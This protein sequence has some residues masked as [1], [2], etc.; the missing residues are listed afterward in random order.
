MNRATCILMLLILAGGC[1]VRNY[2]MNAAGDA[3][4]QSGSAIGA[5]HDPELVRGAAPFSLKLMESVLAETPRHAGLLEAAARG[6]TQ[7]AYTFVQQ[8][9]ERAEADDV[10]LAKAQRE[11]ARRLYHRARDYGLRALE[12]RHPGFRAQFDHDPRGAL[13]RLAREDSGAL[14]WTTI[15]WAAAIALSKESAEAVADL[16]RVDALVRRVRE[17]DPDMD[18]GGLH[19]FLIS[20]E[21]GRPGAANPEAQARQHLAHAL[22]LSGGQ[23]AGPYVA[24]A[25]GACVPAQN[26]REFVA[27]LEKALAIDPGARAEWRLENTIMQKRARWLLARADELFVE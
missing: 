16:R 12:A 2:A 18:A 21:M 5:H 26:R 14:Y 23:K 7:Y 10:A 6:F 4:A 3:L 27:M 9:A 1:S 15:S 17:L 22:R 19:T 11:R 25:E 13:M 8:D 20:Y 24:F